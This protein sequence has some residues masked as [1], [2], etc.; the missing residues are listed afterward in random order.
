VVGGCPFLRHYNFGCLTLRDFR[1]ILTRQ[2]RLLV[3]RHNLVGW[4]ITAIVCL[5]RD[6]I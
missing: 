5:I 3:Y 1:P 4:T 6:R 2:M